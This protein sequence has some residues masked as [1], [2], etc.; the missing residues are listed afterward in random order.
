MLD[1]FPGDDRLATPGKTVANLRKHIY[2]QPGAQATGTQRPGT[3][4]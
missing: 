2:H 4:Q 1:G 3:L